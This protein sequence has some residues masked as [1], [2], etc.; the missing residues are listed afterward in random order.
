MFKK[1]FRWFQAREENNKVENW[2]L[3]TWDS[4]CIYI[5]V[6]P[7]GEKAWS[8]KFRWTDIEKIC[9][10]ATDYMHS[11]NIYFYTTTG[12]GC[13]MIPTE[14]KGGCELWMLVLEQKL[15][16]I[17]LAVKAVRSLEGTFCW[18]VSS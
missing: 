10:G 18:S 3:V 5:N 15:F 17:D 2:F 1:I 7:P 14:A 13:Y 9:F 12:A 8:D 16:D 11:D 6:S 4:E